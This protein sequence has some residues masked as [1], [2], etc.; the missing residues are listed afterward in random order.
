[1]SYVAPDEKPDA[2]ITYTVLVETNN[3]HCI[4]TIN[5]IKSIKNCDSFTAFYKFFISHKL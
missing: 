1:M 5:Q 2:R 4:I 3:A